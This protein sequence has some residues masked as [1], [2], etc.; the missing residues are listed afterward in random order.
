MPNRFSCFDGYFPGR[1][2]DGKYAVF[3]ADRGDLLSVV[4][5]DVGD[6][7]GIGAGGTERAA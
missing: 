6:D 4:R 3:Y 1:G 5:A 2:E 7:I